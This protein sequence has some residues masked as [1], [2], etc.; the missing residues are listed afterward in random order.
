VRLL[1]ASVLRWAFVA[2]AAVPS[3][4]C[5]G[6][7]YTARINSVEGKVEQAKEVGAEQSSPYEY[8]SAKERVLKAREEAARADYSDAIDLLDEAEE[9]A[10]KAI[11]QAAAVRKGAGR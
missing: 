1:R 7:W 6:V 4:G 5:G 11:Q 9:F 10:D 2:F 8:Y 3:V